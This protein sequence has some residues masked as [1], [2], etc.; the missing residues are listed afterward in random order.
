MLLSVE[1]ESADCLCDE[2]A[3]RENQFPE[4]TKTDSSRTGQVAC[5]CNALL[6]VIGGRSLYRAQRDS[7]VNMGLRGRGGSVVR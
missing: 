1:G 7:Y 6:C 3:C 5:L 2:G 4:K